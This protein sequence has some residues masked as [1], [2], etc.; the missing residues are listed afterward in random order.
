MNKK[1]DDYQHA[2]L[3]RAIE[4]QVIPRLMMAHKSDKERAK[5]QLIETKNK[6]IFSKEAIE[7]FTRVLLSNDADISKNYVEALVDEGVNL[8]DIY[9]ELFQ[10]SARLLG[11]IW[12]EDVEDFSAVTCFFKSSTVLMNGTKF[13]WAF[14]NLL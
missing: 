10:P 8:E 11:T 7:D 5:S 9:L 6:H 14:F 13:F 12:E 3:V 4:T 2:W 1:G